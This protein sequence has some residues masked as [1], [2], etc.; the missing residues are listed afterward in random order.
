VKARI[1]GE[2]RILRLGGIGEIAR[3]AMTAAS[4]SELLKWAVCPIKPEDLRHPRYFGTREDSIHFLN[5]GEGLTGWGTPLP[6][7]SVLEYPNDDSPRP[8][9]SAS[10]FPIDVAAA[11]SL[12]L[13]ENPPEWTESK[14]QSRG[15]LHNAT[16]CGEITV[17]LPGEPDELKSGDAIEY[18]NDLE[19]EI[20]LAAALPDCCLSKD[21]L[22]D[23]VEKVALQLPGND[24][25]RKLGSV[26]EYLVA[27][28]VA[29][30]DALLRI[31]PTLSAGAFAKWIGSYQFQQYLHRSCNRLTRAPSV[32]RLLPTPEGIQAEVGRVRNSLQIEIARFALFLGCPHESDPGESDQSSGKGDTSTLRKQDGSLMDSVN[33]SQAQRYLGITARQRQKLMRKGSLRVLGD[34]RNRRIAVQSLLKYLPAPKDAN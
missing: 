7:I 26:R 33:F 18:G 29:Y 12:L 25:T 17:P 32:W 5:S 20:A 10:V 4:Q 24:L 30:D 8:H 31:W 15:L 13:V 22:A 34:G 3:G 11:P 19:T 2:G 21:S 28:L 6:V 23:D 14:F 27:A 9:L 1:L 16:A